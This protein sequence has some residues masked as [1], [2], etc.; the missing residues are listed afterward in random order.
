MTSRAKLV[1]AIAA[2]LAVGL[3][4]IIGVSLWRGGGDDQTVT[5]W[6][7]N[8]DLEKAGELAAQFEEE[9]PDYS[10]ELIETTADTMANR[11]SV[12]LDSGE[13]P[14][15]ITELGS[16]TR[17]YIEEG[18]LSDLTSLYDDEMPQ[19]DFIETA[20]DAVSG[21]DG[22][23]YAVPY[24]WDAIA[25]LYNVEMFDE[26]GMEA[27]TTWDEFEEAAR[28]ITDQTDAYGV[29]WPMNG[30]PHD[31]VLRTMGFALS[32]GATITDGLPAFPNDSLERA[33]E[34]MGGSVHQG[35]ASPSS[36]E[37]DNSGVRELFINEQIAMYI[38]GVF[39]TVQITDAGLTV[40]T[41]IT[42]GPDGPGTQ[43]AD[44]WVYVIPED[45]DNKSAAELLVKFLTRPEN[46]NYLTMT[47]PARTS[48]AEDPR[49]HE[50]LQAAHYSQ[51]FEYSAPPTNDPRWISMLPYVYGE[52]Q[53]VALGSSSPTESAENITGELNRVTDQ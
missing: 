9:H 27:P 25:M 13:A 28:A 45:A 20:L 1:V 51:V 31:L 53:S 26:I 2:A 18:Q 4:A 23:V 32:A 42:P 52:V 17:T 49:F 34:I 40:G 43:I 29:A 11:I 24:R 39:D 50:D 33:L 10:V 41:A 5:W 38:G 35:W 3:A 7:P 21:D 22:N 30:N 47:Y 36:L 8:W 46:M 48:A 14:D 19:S 16:R 6:V 37:V 12:A 15:V 44:G